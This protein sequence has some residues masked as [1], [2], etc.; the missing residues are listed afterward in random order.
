MDQEHKDYIDLLLQKSSEA[1]H[2]PDAMNFAQAALNAAHA[3]A[4]MDNI[5]R[6]N[7]TT[8]NEE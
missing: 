2:A 4:V 8:P 7:R 6:G 1:K 3:L 5:R